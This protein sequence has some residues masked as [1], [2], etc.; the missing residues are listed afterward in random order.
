MAATSR[1]PRYRASLADWALAGVSVVFA[2]AVAEVGVRLWLDAHQQAELPHAFVDETQQRRLAWLERHASQSLDSQYG[3]DTSDALLGWRLRPELSVRSFKEGSYDVAITSNPQGLR[4]TRPVTE[5][6][7]QGVTRIGIF[8]DSQTFGEGVNDWETYSAQLEALLANYE[9]LNFG[10]HGYGTDQMLLRYETQGQRYDLDMV[11][12]AFAWFHLERNIADFSFYAKPQFQVDGDEL[13]LR[14]IPVPLPGTLLAERPNADW[15]LSDHS[16][17]ARWA[18]QRVRNLRQRA[19][20][21][22]DSRA[23][24]LTRMLITRF[25][26]Q[27]H[28]VGSRFVLMSIDETRPQMDPLLA[29]LADELGVELLDLTPRLRALNAAGVDYRL[30]N[31]GHWNA[32]GHRLVAFE[33]R[34][35]ICRRHHSGICD[36]ALPSMQ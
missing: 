18:W 12:L 8:G 25:A 27:A 15:M 5:Q 20:Y 13:R 22:A 1:T 26:R 7:P 31:D 19:L 17:L 11:I 23:W 30:A 4:G 3:F 35:H 2:I 6:K 36:H 14:N 10:V 9:I 34:R 21:R 28:A 33:I 32:T 29:E 16:V 24:A